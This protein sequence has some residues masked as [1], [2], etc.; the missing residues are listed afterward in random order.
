MTSSLINN[1]SCG[2]KTSK[3]VLFVDSEENSTTEDTDLIRLLSGQQKHREIEF[4]S[5]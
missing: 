1:F 2:A 3:D 5:Q 4:E